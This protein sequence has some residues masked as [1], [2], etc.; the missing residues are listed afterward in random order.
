MTKIIAFASRPD[1]AEAF[2]RFGKELGLELTLIKE[3]LGKNNVELTKG[4]EAV[5]ILGNDDASEPVIK[6]LAENDVKYLALRSAGYNNVDVKAAKTYGIRF[7]NA[8][9]SPNCVADFSVLHILMAI[10]KFKRI[11]L[12][13]NANDYS[14]VGNQGK[15]LKNL[16]VGII[17]TGRIGA[18]VARDLSGFGCKIIGYDVYQN[19]SLK[20]I[21]TY[22]S[23]D[24]LY[25]QADVITLHT[26]LF[27]SNFHMLNSDAFAAMK[28][29]VAIVN[30]ARGELID[31][32][33]LIAALESG[34]VGAAGLDVLEGELG[35][36]H[37]NHS[38]DL[39]R[40][41]HLAIL[42]GFP[43]VTITP[44]I[45]FYTDQAVSDM[46]EVALRS[47]VSF[48]KDGQSNWEIK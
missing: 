32:E 1:E 48:V 3:P 9:Y 31:T 30:C 39:V 28:D 37:A 12:R 18:T 45:A 33:A 29:G 27:E 43:N 22:V 6:A 8:T 15:E 11:A 24:Q 34:K 47:L 20:D 23:L 26:P 36:F 17:G 4:F 7:S 10:R 19:D 41:D 2:A 42:E 25:A 46:V 35:I 38:T 16:T 21:L 5:S 14:L 44:H 13:N 40:N